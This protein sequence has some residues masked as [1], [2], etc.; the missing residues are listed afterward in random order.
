VSYFKDKLKTTKSSSDLD[1]VFSIFLDINDS[2][3]HIIMSDNI[4]LA[5]KEY[6][7]VEEFTEEHMPIFEQINDRIFKDPVVPNL[8]TKEKIQPKNEDRQNKFKQKYKL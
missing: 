8:I 2:K 7:K 3:D 6:Y 4:I 5:I 1:G